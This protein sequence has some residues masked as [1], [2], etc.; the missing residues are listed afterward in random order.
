MKTKFFWALALIFATVF[1]FTSTVSAQISTYNSS[2]QVQNLS[3][4]SD[5]T[6]AITYYNQDGSVDNTVNDTVD[7]GSSNTYFPIDASAGFNGSVV[8]SSDQPVA[9]IANVVGNGFDFGASY[10]SFD[11]GAQSVA[12]P[13]IMKGN[14]GFNTWFNVQNT[15]TSSASVTVSYAGTSCTENAT[16]AP[17]AA[18]TFDQSANTCLPSSY[19]GAASVS[20]GSG[21]TI[22]ATGMQVGTTT[23]FAYNGFTVG[24]TEVAI[25]LV[26]ANNSGYIT[27]IQIQ[28]T[29]GTDTDVT[30]AYEPVSGLGT[31]CTE[32]KTVTAG[33][34]ATF[35]LYAFTFSGDPDPGSDNCSFGSLFV[36][37]ASVSANSASQPLVAVV[38]Q[39]N[40]SANKGSAYNGFDPSL[41]TDT[42]VMPL[43]MD[44]NSGFYTGI[45]ILN[46]SSTATTVDCTF[47]NSDGSVSKTFNF[48]SIANGEAL[49]HIQNNQLA[50]GFVGSGVC[51]ANASGAVILGVVN[52]L[53]PSG[54][55]DQ[56]F[57]YEGFNN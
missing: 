42:V 18:A 30:L 27:G 46:V 12:M 28:N 41:A 21:D 3:D 47:T 9:A 22:V 52:E 23:L 6:I 8:I 19:V 40:L 51:T 33:S 5:A 37:G 29:G 35:A 7:A 48:A 10:G 14:S 4:S 53:G 55:L 25:P 17:G 45:N 34:S 36:G 2:F 56:L 54:S 11:S 43:I 20:G 16:V 13:L 38:N 26:N 24:S 49:N 31:A 1:A 57:S 50:N 39:L 44:R 32:T 15:G